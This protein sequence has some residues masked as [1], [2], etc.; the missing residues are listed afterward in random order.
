MGYHRFGSKRRDY[1]WWREQMKA[2]DA[3]LGEHPVCVHCGKPVTPEQSWDESHIAVP[4]A[5]GGRKTGVGHRAC[6][7]KD[8]YEVVAPMLAKCRRVAKRHK[9]EKGPGLGRHPLPAGRRSPVSKTFRRGL[10][11]RKTL[12]QKLAETRARR[13][14]LTQLPEIG[15]DGAHS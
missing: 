8:N 10:V 1:V 15:G 7:R 11:A 14:I 13:A 2:L 3:G 12:S 9:G 4:K 5:L 6:N